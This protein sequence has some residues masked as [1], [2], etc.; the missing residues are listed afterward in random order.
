LFLQKK[1]APVTVVRKIG[2]LTGPHPGKARILAYDGSGASA[3]CKDLVL[4]SRYEISV[5]DAKGSL[6]TH[7]IVNG[8]LNAKTFGQKFLDPFTGIKII[9]MRRVSY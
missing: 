9:T 2:N 8:P 3:I 4:G 1:S 7:A 5:F 6:C